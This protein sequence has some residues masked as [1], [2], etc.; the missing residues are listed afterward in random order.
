MTPYLCQVL[1]RG[2]GPLL[3]ETVQV[4]VADLFIRNEPGIV[5]Q[6]EVTR[7]GRA[8]D[9]QPVGNLL[10]RARL[11]REQLD[12]GPS[13]RIAERVE[14]VLQPTRLNAHLEY[15]NGRVTVTELLR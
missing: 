10:D 7:D 3:V 2:F 15:G 8:A 13:V 4:P 14:G 6:A 1:P 9:R 12:D 11:P 5:Q